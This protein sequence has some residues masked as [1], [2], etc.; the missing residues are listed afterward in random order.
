MRQLID[1]LPLL[2]FFIVYQLDGRIISLG[3]WEYTLDGIF[4]ATAVM[5][6]AT[7]IQVVL[8]LLLTGRLEKQLLWT[9]VAVLV[10]GG[11]T[12]MLRD[13]RFIQWKPTVINWALMVVFVGSQFIGKRNLVERMIGSQIQLPRAVWRRTCWL[14]SA[15]FGVVGTLNI[16]VAYRF[17]EATW[18]SYKMYS[19]I[20]F[21]L[22]LMV[23]TTAVIGPHLK[24][25]TSGDQP[26]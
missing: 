12:L 19:A 16:V 15:H 7:A 18:V 2:L 22:L 21:T 24:G 4:S 1:L 6:I 17:S 13:E 20:G 8:T 10:L 25:Q 26:R 14:W 23:L 11:A 3:G 5:M 9:A